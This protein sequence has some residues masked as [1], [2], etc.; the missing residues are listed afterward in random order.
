MGKFISCQI[1]AVTE[2]KQATSKDLRH[3]FGIAMLMGEKPAPIHIVSDLLGHADTSPTESY[4][5]ALD[6]EKRSMVLQEWE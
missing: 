1:I 3:G 6:E 2:G 4:L 5:R